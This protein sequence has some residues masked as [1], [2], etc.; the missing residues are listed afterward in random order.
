M[1]KNNKFKGLDTK[2]LAEALIRSTL[3]GVA[4][5]A[6]ASF[7]CAFVC[8]FLS[9]DGLI[10]SIAAFAIGAVIAGVLFYF[11]HFRPSVKSNAK[12]LDSY[13]LDERV[14]TMV[15]LEGEDSFIAR[16]Q[17]E[18]ATAKLATIEPKQI[19][20]RISTL[21]IVLA[22]V[23]ALLFAGM[24]VIEGLSSIGIIPTGSEVW[25]MIFPPEPPPEYNLVYTAG[26]GGYLIGEDKQTVTEGEDA[27]PVLAVADDG[28]MFYAWS[29]GVT[30][31]HR[32]DESVNR[33]ITVNAVFIAVDD[34]ADKPDD[35]DEPDDVP[36]DKGPGQPNGDPS[37]SG[38]GKYVET[39]QV[40]DG[41]T[42]YRDVYEEFYN[43]AMEYIEKGEAIP[44][45]IRAIIEAY[46]NIIQ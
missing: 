25:Q 33:P 18:D 37:N 44:D 38:G 20:F 30:T 7:L 9:F 5:G 41:E 28:F 22:S 3:W 2:L 19:K 14:I 12:R 26:K 23:F 17:R 1:T 31:P 45:N 21:V 29:D 10:L 24:A 43:K 42:Y 11:L 40:I 6:A 8:W 15:E 39:N 34:L 46:Y 13:G 16:K 36:G 32:T 35:K 4:V 27:T